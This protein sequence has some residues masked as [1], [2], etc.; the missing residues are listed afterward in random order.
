MSEENKDKNLKIEKREEMPKSYG[1]LMDHVHEDQRKNKKKRI[2]PKGRWLV[3]LFVLLIVIINLVNIYPLLKPGYPA[4]DSALMTSVSQMHLVEKN[5]TSDWIHNSFLGSP[6]YLYNNP[7]IPHFVYLI[8][9]V[10]SF[11]SIAYIVKILTALFYILIPVS[12]YFFVRYVSKKEF[13][14][15]LAAILFSAPP[16]LLIWIPEVRDVFANSGFVPWLVNLINVDPSAL[17]TLFSLFL[18]PLAAIYYLKTIRNFRLK[19]LLI[20]VTFITLISL[21]SSMAFQAFLILMIILTASELILGNPGL[22]LK[23]SIGVFLVMLGTVS[24]WFNF[25][26][27]SNLYLN[28]QSGA[29]F[30]DIISLLPL[31]FIILPILATL[32]FLFFDR[33]PKL[34]IFFISF[35]WTF[36]FSFTII[37]WIY[38]DKSVSPFPLR[39]LPQLW[40]GMSILV[41]YLLSLGILGIKSIVTYR[42]TKE[43][44]N[45][46]LVG[47]IVIFLCLGVGL[48]TWHFTKSNELL[49]PI[50]LQEIENSDEYLVAKWL[51]GKMEGDWERVFVNGNLSDSLDSFADISQV[52]GV[53]NLS[54]I[55]DLWKK[56][57]DEIEKGHDVLK[58]ENYL[59]IIGVRYIVVNKQG[60][61]V[62]RNKW[63]YYYPDKFKES[64]LLTL[65]KKIGSYSIYKVG[66]ES[67]S[68]AQ[69]VDNTWYH[70]LMEKDFESSLGLYAEILDNDESVLH[71]DWYT[72]SQFHIKTELKENQGLVIK[73]SYYR[74]WQAEMNNQPV[75]LEKDPLGFIYLKPEKTGE[76]SILVNL[77]KDLAQYIGYSLFVLTLILIFLTRTKKIKTLT[78]NYQDAPSHKGLAPKEEQKEASFVDMMTNHEDQ[79]EKV[80]GQVKDHYQKTED[81]DW[82]QGTD[83]FAS[84]SGYF[85]KNRGILTKKMIDKFGQGQKYLDAGCGTG[86]LLRHLP[87]G[88]IGLDINAQNIA[89]AKKNVPDAALIVADI[90]NI[91]YPSNMF[92]TIVCS[93]VLDRLPD[94]KRAIKEILR[95]LKPGGVLIGTVPRE[96]PL[97]RLRFLSSAYSP[98]PYR[99]E[100]S[101]KEVDVLLASFEKVMVSPALSYMAWAFVVKKKESIYE[102]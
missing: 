88:A 66:L 89:Q 96:N 22:K 38:W 26:F 69:I 53:C 83:N 70:D 100:Y 55:N 102:L 78:K 31:G 8:K 64:G 77:E 74:T 14:A 95:V 84:L 25:S 34:Q 13:T 68:L 65:R 81:V 51:E 46:A 39:Y 87:K 59:R 94:S 1:L 30:R 92:D 27:V 32:L 15:V 75:Q 79:L 85:H 28:T 43:R 19:Y 58:T 98:E 90:T 91:P 24:I 61:E 10:F 36:I 54:Y 57:A 56:A 45:I 12:I 71:F 29:V 67:D 49:E 73:E 60:D 76:V 17:N 99:F 6:W 42:F 93:E 44:T 82:I 52:K 16:Y 3:L 97:W 72:E 62:E 86:F 21:S 80:S 20:A 50:S 47:L 33:K 5:M 40:M 2:F 37:A 35:A 48:T 4:I 101:R 63:D 9:L 41:A 18:F 11:L 7:L 23:R